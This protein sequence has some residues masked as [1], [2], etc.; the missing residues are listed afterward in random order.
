MFPGR[1]TEALDNGLR[2]LIEGTQGFGLSIYH[3]AEYPKATS[4]DTT[5]SGF[6]SEVGLSPRRITE[7]VLVFRT[8]PIRVAGDQAGK[9]HEEVSWETI[10][11][12]SHYPWEIREFTSVT[13]LPRR[14]G[15]FDWELARRAVD[16]NRPT[17]VVITGLDYLDFD[18]YGAIDPARFGDRVSGFID[19]LRGRLGVPVSYV[20]T[21]PRLEHTFKLETFASRTCDVGKAQVTV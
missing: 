16:V 19:Q 11:A 9:L 21:S 15:R 17:R 5:A 18:C 6:L 20:S 14:V 1:P 8:F 7:V 10:R 4:R 12:E 2:V 3:S 13:N